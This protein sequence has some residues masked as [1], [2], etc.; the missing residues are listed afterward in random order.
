MERDNDNLDESSDYSDDDD[1]YDDVPSGY[2]FEPEFTE[3]EV[4][5]NRR[6]KQREE[7]ES[8]ETEQESQHGGLDE[9][10]RMDDKYWCFLWCV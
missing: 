9:R 7:S 5:E 6:K 4:E 10:N 3:E 2:R 1:I 8:E